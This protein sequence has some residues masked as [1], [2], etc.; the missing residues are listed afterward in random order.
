M[1]KHEPVLYMTYSQVITL[2]AAAAAAERERI[3]KLLEA[4]AMAQSEDCAMPIDWKHCQN[5]WQMASLIAL[6]K[7]EN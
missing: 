1:S 7:G 4:S 5:C 2:E 3:I 6:I